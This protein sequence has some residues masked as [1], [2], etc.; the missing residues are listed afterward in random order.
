MMNSS[1]I[2]ATGGGGSPGCRCINATSILSSLAAERRCTT[3]AGNDGIIVS[4]DKPCLGFDDRFGSSGC[5]PYNLMFDPDCAADESGATT[6]GSVSP[7]GDYCYRSWC[8]VDVDEC[9][10]KSDERIFRSEYF[11]D[12]NLVS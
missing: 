4:V 11:S 9:M 6:P 3:P 8:Y 5:A 10:L 1:S 7:I 12:E 2:F